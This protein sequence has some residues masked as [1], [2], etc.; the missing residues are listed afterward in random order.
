MRVN[1]SPIHSNAKSAGAQRL[2]IF[3]WESM[4]AHSLQFILALKYFQSPARVPYLYLG[5][6]G[7]NFNPL[8][9]GS[10]NGQN[11]STHLRQKSPI[12]KKQFERAEEV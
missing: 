1:E 6:V 3:L 4:G 7:G 9:L 8:H 5:L 12:G 11:F 2:S 10:C